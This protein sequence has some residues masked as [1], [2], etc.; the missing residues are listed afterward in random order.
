MI[1]RNPIHRNIFIYKDIDHR[2][3][4]VFYCRTI[5]HLLGPR[6]HTSMLH[7]PRQRCIVQ[8]RQCIRPTSSY[9]GS[10]CLSESSMRYL[11]AESCKYRFKQKGKPWDLTLIEMFT[12]TLNRQQRQKLCAGGSGETIDSATASQHP[13]PPIEVGDNATSGMVYQLATGRAIS[14]F[15]PSTV[16]KKYR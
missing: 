16:G 6:M 2:V 14:P 12:N 11:S 4:R 7:R 1:H 15:A 9:V 10:C 3:H 5:R 8:L 13:I